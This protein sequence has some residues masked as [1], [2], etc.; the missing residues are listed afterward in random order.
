MSRRVI[1]GRRFRGPATSGNGGYSCGLIARE[2]AGPGEGAVEVKLTA[3]PPLDKELTLAAR[4]QGVAMLDGD[5][6]I[7]VGAAAALDLEAPPSPGLNAAR[8]GEKHFAARDRH[9]LPECFVCGI[10]RKTPDALC[11][12]TGPFDASGTVAAPWTPA[13]D[14]ADDDG[15]IPTEIIWAALDCPGYFGLQ[16]PGL[17]ALLGKMTAQ[18][19]AAPRAGEDC[20][21]IGWRLGGEGRKHYAGSA[22]YNSDGA[23]LG[24]ARQ[25]WIELKQ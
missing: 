20:V 8:E 14:L 19:A 10:H 24:K 17:T 13:P 21:V 6:V 11:L 16:K 3:P 4:D 15:T 22:L 23:L 1:I 2:I 5:A 18:A 7:G 9:P 12:H 25:V